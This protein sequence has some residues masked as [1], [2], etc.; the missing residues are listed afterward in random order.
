MRPHWRTSRA[1]PNRSGDTVFSAI[2]A[3][4]SVPSGRLHVREAG[5]IRRA[6]YHRSRYPADLLRL[7]AGLIGGAER[8]E[9][10]RPD[11]TVELCPGVRPFLL[12]S[13]SGSRKTAHDCVI[14]FKSRTLFKVDFSGRRVSRHGEGSG[15]TCGIGDGPGPGKSRRAF[16]ICRS[17]FEKTL[18]LPVRNVTRRA[19]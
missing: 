12:I 2:E 10:A 11:R 3:D 16:L 18:F 7:A 6:A 19:K 14:D 8:E 4:G 1:W 5:H 17:P 13:E 9:S 15:K